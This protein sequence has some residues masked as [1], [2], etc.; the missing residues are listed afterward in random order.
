MKDAASNGHV[1]GIDAPT[2]ETGFHGGLQSCLLSDAAT[3]P[4]APPVLIG[5]TDPPTF[6][7]V[8]PNGQ[9]PVVLVCDHASNVI[10]AQLNSLGLGK[11]E[12]NQHIAWDIGAAQVAQLL[13]ARLNAPAVLAGYSR[14]VIDCN[15]P[16][17]HPT[18]M[19]EV[20][21][22]IFIPGNRDLSDQEA[23][24]RLNEVF[25]PYHH[26]ITQ[27]LA[28]RWRHGHGRAPALIAIHSFTPVMNGFR[29]PWQL[30][31]LWNRDPRLAEPLLTRFGANI[32]WCVGD[33]Q[34]YSGREVGFTMDTHGGAAGL[35]HVEVEI[36]QDLLVDNEG[37][38]YWADRIG[39]AL[40]AILLDKTL[41]EI[42]HY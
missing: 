7:L 28:H 33:N 26:A 17:G 15:R 39:D 10:P 21:D 14:L 12:L 40:E 23:E 38:A 22:G 35:P 4:V 18:S 11:H 25:W 2:H 42:R 32:E 34:P 37:C 31:V 41:Y 29:R 30:G 5:S 3:Q 1:E 27:A 9:A 36:R 19:A 13:A 20:S 6:T 24:A 8:N 16:P